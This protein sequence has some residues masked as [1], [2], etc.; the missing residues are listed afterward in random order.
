M[1]TAYK[2]QKAAVKSVDINNLMNQGAEQIGNIYIRS[3]EMFGYREFEQFEIINRD[4]MLIYV[5]S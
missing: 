5:M 3:Q 1:A 4:R 2:A